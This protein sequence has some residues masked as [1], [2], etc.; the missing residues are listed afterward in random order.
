MGF[1]EIETND[2]HGHKLI[3]SLFP[4]NTGMLDFCD[5]PVKKKSYDAHIIVYIALLKYISRR[6]VF[7]F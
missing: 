6:K 7:L 1:M 3:A 4:V 2:S 5:V